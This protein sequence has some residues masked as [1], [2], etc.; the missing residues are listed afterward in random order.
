MI[1]NVLGETLKPGNKVRPPC[2]KRGSVASVQ[3]QEDLC[4][5][6]DSQI[7]LWVLRISHSDASLQPGRA[8]NCHT[9]SLFS[10]RVLFESCVCFVI[11]TLVGGR[12]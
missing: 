1:L 8:W 6:P 11:G 10:P 7:L 12:T 3:P 2:R 5:S 4:D 9:R